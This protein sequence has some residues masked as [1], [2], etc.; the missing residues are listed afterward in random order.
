MRLLINNN[1]IVIEILKGKQKNGQRIGVILTT[2]YRRQHKAA[3]SFLT[4]KS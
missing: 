2:K 3:S 4:P 1:Y